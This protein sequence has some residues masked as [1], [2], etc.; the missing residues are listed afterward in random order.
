M[1]QMGALPDEPAG[2]PT[3]DDVGGVT[4]VFRV[5]GPGNARLDI[6][7]SGGVEIK[8]SNALFLNFGQEARAQQFLDL[9]M[10]QGFD[11]TQI[12]TFRVPTSY[13]DELRAS[14]VPESMARQFPD[15][16]FAV[17][18][19][20]APDQFGLRAALFDNLLAHIIP[21]SG[22]YW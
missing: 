21:G 20:Q 2:G 9:R 10:S 1:G 7:P 19:N 11:G 4:N 18:V 6:S 8:G 22:R 17:D 12:K 13:V 3:A 15:S 16:P 5:E 14:A